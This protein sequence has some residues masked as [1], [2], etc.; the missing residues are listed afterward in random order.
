MH[1]LLQ[2]QRCRRHARAGAHSPN[3]E[4]LHTAGAALLS[5]CHSNV[6]LRRQVALCFMHSHCSVFWVESPSLLACFSIAWYLAKNTLVK[7]P[8]ILHHPKQHAPDHN[9]Q[10]KQDAPD[11]NSTGWASA[12]PP[13]SS[14]LTT[15]PPKTYKPYH[16][17][18][19]TLG[20]PSNPTRQDQAHHRDVTINILVRALNSVLSMSPLAQGS[21]WQSSKRRVKDP[22]TKPSQPAILEL[23]YQRPGKRGCESWQMQSRMGV[24]TATGTGG[25]GSSS[26]STLL[27]PS[28]RRDLLSGS[29]AWAIKINIH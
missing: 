24:L 6:H 21:Q 7:N 13:P 1:R 18:S 16:Q 4:H 27:P 17:T 11:C 14:S 23:G 26:R 8:Q 12:P 9:P 22:A 20:K 5:S 28:W 3:P 15:R 2:H 25:L 10:P 29:H 19:E